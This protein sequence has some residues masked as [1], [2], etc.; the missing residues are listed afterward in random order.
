M[1]ETIKSKS[2]A[3]D[4]KLFEQMINNKLEKLKLYSV[5]K[6]ADKIETNRN[7]RY[8]DSQIRHIIDFYIKKADK[9][10]SWLIAKKPL[11]GFSCASCESYIGDLKNTKEFTPWSKY[12]NREDKN[13]RYGSGFSR[14]LN[15]LNID[16]KNQLDAIKDNA[17]ESDNE[18][19]TSVE[20]KTSQHRRFSKNLSS[21]DVYNTNINST[22]KNNKHLEIF[23]KI[24]INK[25]SRQ[26]ISNNNTTNLNNNEFHS[27]DRNENGKNNEM[28][29]SNILNNENDNDKYKHKNNEDNKKT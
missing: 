20:P 3:E 12:P 23:P 17:Y 10:E 8:L 4:L 9:T 13:Y 21:V 24:S 26:E 25:N 28:N 14:M 15:M 18:G 2:G 29:E 27:V 6:L 11:G 19:R 22:H 1:A 5:R 16:F 7:I